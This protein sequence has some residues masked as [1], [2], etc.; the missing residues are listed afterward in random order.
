MIDEEDLPSGIACCQ[1]TIARADFLKGLEHFRAMARRIDRYQRTKI[2]VSASPGGIELMT[3]T[4][5]VDIPARGFWIGKATF[6]AT[7]IFGFVSNPPAEPELRVIT[8]GQ[9]IW[10]NKTSV[11]CVWKEPKAQRKGRSAITLS[12]KKAEDILRAALPSNAEVCRFPPGTP[13]GLYAVD[14]ETDLIF[15]V[16]IPDS[17]RVGSTDCWAVSKVS[18]LARYV[19]GMGE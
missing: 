10:I 2:T 6:N 12:W 19:G 14:R 5:G 8:D 3:T 13:H 15:T 7:L 16:V 11:P 18:R 17:G 4:V 1:V 9:R